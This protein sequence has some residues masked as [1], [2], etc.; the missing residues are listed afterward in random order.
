MVKNPL[1]RP[2]FLGG[3]GIGGVPLDSHDNIQFSK[4]FGLRVFT[5]GKFSVLAEMRNGKK[6]LG[7]G[8]GSRNRRGRVKV[9]KKIHFLTELMCVFCLVDLSQLGVFLALREMV[10]IVYLCLEKC[11]T[12]KIN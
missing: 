5:F 6:T 8:E 1:I 4:L 9:K 11:H 3:G 7:P 2:Y 10:F 12:K